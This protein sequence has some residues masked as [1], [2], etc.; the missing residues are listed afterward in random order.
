MAMLEIH[1]IWPRMAPFLCFCALRGPSAVADVSLAGAVVP[2]FFPLLMSG[3]AKKMSRI[4]RLAR[5]F[6]RNR[7]VLVA[8]GRRQAAIFGCCRP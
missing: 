8:R 4:L 7:C 2:F 3:L 5:A 1:V 6:R